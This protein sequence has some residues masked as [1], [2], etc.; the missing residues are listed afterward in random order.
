MQIEAWVEYFTASVAYEWSN[1][2]LS[3]LT[4]YV[5]D[6]TNATTIILWAQN[7][8]WVGYPD[9]TTPTEPGQSG[10]ITG[11]CSL[12]PNNI[13]VTPDG[14]VLYNSS[15]E[16]AGF[17][18]V[19]GGG[20]QNIV[21]VSGGAIEEY[22]YN[23]SFSN[24]GS[25]FDDNIVLGFAFEGLLTGE[26]VIPAGCGTLMQV[27]WDWSAEPGFQDS[28]I[29]IP[30]SDYTFSNQQ[31]EAINLENFIH[32]SGCDNQMALN[33]TSEVSYPL[34]DQ[35]V[36]QE[37]NPIDYYFNLE[38][39]DFEYYPNLWTDYATVGYYEK[40][41][42]NNNIWTSNGY[43]DGSSPERTFSEETS[44]GQIFISDNE[45][46]NLISDCSL[47]LNN[48]NVSERVILDSSGNLNKGLLIGDYKITKTEKN[49]P[50]RRDSFIRVAKKAS[51]VK[52]AL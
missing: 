32:I 17:Q 37:S 28:I 31:S 47:E 9:S 7:N 41:E 21:S 39:L 16:I 3:Q 4:E 34:I 44:V 14:Y 42:N 23:V 18:M 38:T 5:E 24:Q 30:I 35:C 25:S 43:W 22:S 6:G 50:M 49:E 46:Q 29:E 19:F 51:K 45:N 52:G 12:P 36:F 11:G 33:Y 13:F 10:Y 1:E 26:G 48:G 27:E 8:F 20:L 15:Q 2:Y 40:D